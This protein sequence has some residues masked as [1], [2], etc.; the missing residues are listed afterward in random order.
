MSYIRTFT[1]WFDSNP[2]R[3]WIL[4]F[5]ARPIDIDFDSRSLGKKTKQE[6][7]QQQLVGLLLDSYRPFFLLL[8]LF[9]LGGG[10]GL[11]VLFLFFGFFLTWYGQRHR[12][13]LYFY[14]SLNDFDLHSRSE[15]MWKHHL[16][17]SFSSKLRN[18]FA[19]AC[20]LW[21]PLDLFH[22][23]NIHGR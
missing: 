18:R 4:Y 22:T 16:L 7:R 20:C 8:L 14:D 19:T 1:S 21:K 15:F 12:C 2:I 6:Q 10:G 13:T 3:W 9:F 11:I 5:D 17:C 23:I